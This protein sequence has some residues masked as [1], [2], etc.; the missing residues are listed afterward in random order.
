MSAQ[1]PFALTAPGTLAAKMVK[2]DMI[3]E[4]TAHV[5]DQFGAN[6]KVPLTWRLGKGARPQVGELWTVERDAAA[7]TWVFKACLSA[8][9]PSVTADVAVGSATDQILTGLAD[10]GLLTDEANRLV[11]WSPW[12][13][14]LP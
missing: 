7:G 4:S 8:S 1:S 6:M 11:D 9:N 14:V 3:T 5:I 2:V 12:M 13:N 10:Q